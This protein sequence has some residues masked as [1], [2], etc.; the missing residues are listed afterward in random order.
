M[1][2]EEDRMIAYTWAEYLEELDNPE[3]IAYLPMVRGAVRS[4]DCITEFMQEEYSISIEQFFF[5]GFSK[6]G[7]T[8]WLTGAMENGPL[9]H[10][11]VKA[12][13]PGVWDAINFQEV[14]QN[15]WMSFN[16]WS[17]AVHDFVDNGIMPYMGTPELVHLQNIIDPYF[18]RTR[19]TMPK[20]VI[21]GIMD[22]FQ[23]TDDEQHWWD[24]MPSGP[25]DSDPSEYSNGNTK[26]LM[27]SPNAEHGQSTAIRTDLNAYGMFLTYLLNDWDIPYLTWDYDPANGDITAYT[28][29]GE[30]LSA[31]IWM[32]TTCNE[33]VPDFRRDLRIASLDDPC[34]CGIVGD[35]DTCITT[36]SWWHETKL[37][38]NSDGY[39]YSA[40]VDPP[41][42]NKWSSYIVQVHIRGNHTM[43]WEDERHT[44]FTRGLS[45]LCEPVGAQPKWPNTPC[46][47]F[48]F[49]TR[50][51]VVPNEFPY[52][53]C[54]MDGC[55]GPL[56]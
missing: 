5:T 45:D 19:L 54:S 55:I 1:E 53:P 4:M 40:H 29:G 25:T 9:G 34:N 50:A 15:Q 2:R 24:E 51:S 22:E 21:T 44:L 12:I 10:N 46:G 43:D 32:A 14:F 31:Q 36:E 3:L 56:V 17:F 42:D 16:G 6:R 41:G 47:Y 7:W 52:P 38:V 18:Y 37:T 13:M 27:K 39:S 28:Y 11:R 48:E 26:W 23:M 20:L 35:E 8:T 33:T 49:S 30:V